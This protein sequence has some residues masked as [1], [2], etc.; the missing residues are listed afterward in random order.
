MF[1]PLSNT[2]SFCSALGWVLRA[3]PGCLCHGRLHGGHAGHEERHQGGK[4][5]YTSLSW[6]SGL[7]EQCWG[8]QDDFRVW[9]VPEL[10]QRS[11]EDF[12]VSWKQWKDWPD[13]WVCIRSQMH[14]MPY[15]RCF[16]SRPF[17]QLQ[18]PPFGVLFSLRPPNKRDNESSFP[19][20]FLSFC[21]N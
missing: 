15:S 13:W 8:E 16:Q 3:E 17:M 2:L 4:V 20:I 11:P 9:L 19:L 18:M 12:K 10:G 21:V 7:L 5:R 6:K 14:I 1:V